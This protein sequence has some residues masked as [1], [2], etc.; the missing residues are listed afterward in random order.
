MFEGCSP[1]VDAILNILL[2][3]TSY[4]LKYTKIALF[5]TIELKINNRITAEHG[6]YPVCN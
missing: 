3:Y 6:V 4:M 2:V 5:I 1:D